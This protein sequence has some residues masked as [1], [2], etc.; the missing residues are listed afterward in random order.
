MATTSLQPAPSASFWARWGSRPGPQY[1]IGAEEEVMLVDQAG[2]SLAQCSDVVL[3]RLTE[4]LADHVAPE[5]HAGVVELM[6]G[7]HTTVASATA[8]LS[9]L[10]RELAREVRPQRLAAASAGTHPLGSATATKVSHGERYRFLADSMRFLSRREPTL[11]LHVHIGVRDPEAAVRLLNRLG[12]H[13]PLLIALAANSPFHQGRD[14]G[15]SSARTAIF[16]AFPRTG[17]PRGF[18][19]YADYVDSVDILLAS[20][21]L[22]DPT[23]L[24]WDVRLQPKL[25]T[26]EVRA[27]DAQSSVGESASLIALVQS[28]AR[29]ELEGA[30]TRG[31]AQPELLAENRFIA[32]RD[33]LSAL[34]ID[35]AGRN[36]VPVRA[37]LEQLIDD[38]RP[39]AAALGCSAELEAAGRLAREN[40]AERQRRWVSDGGDL[41]S[42]VSALVQKFSAQGLPARKSTGKSERGD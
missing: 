7:I 28:L 11:A 30:G 5:V 8:E 16:G 9:V 13:V 21:A 26:V 40:G 23:F 19:S 41:P 14:S 24:W 29:L 32:A 31:W 17:V 36:L 27:M 35:P 18:A 20:G 4:N 34:L 15:F 3:A 2:R 39:H 10:R 6:T 33:G 42:L 37:L 38:C 12:Q 22:P 1:T 25:G